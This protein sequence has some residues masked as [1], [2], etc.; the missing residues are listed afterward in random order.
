MQR[1]RSGS[2]LSSRCPVEDPK[3]GRG[4]DFAS[5]LLSGC[6]HCVFRAT[7]SV[8]T[9]CLFFFQLLDCASVDFLFVPSY[10]LPAIRDAAANPHI[11][12]HHAYTWLHRGKDGCGRNG[13]ED[14][15][16][17]QTTKGSRPSSKRM[18]STS[19][20][21]AKLVLSPPLPLPPP[22]PPRPSPL[23]LPPPRPSLPPSSRSSWFWKLPEISQLHARQGVSCRAASQRLA[24]PEDG[25]QPRL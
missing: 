19:T 12:V 1:S 18:T 13:V 4:A 9:C 15:T 17:Q 16:M 6:F 24:T 2:A 10:S 20:E 25:R 11:V 14:G 21:A 8:R 3:G 7:P 23:L 22:F 5:A